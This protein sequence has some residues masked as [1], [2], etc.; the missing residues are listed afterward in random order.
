MS[1]LPQLL[2]SLKQSNASSR[3]SRS[4]GGSGG[5]GRSG[6]STPC[7]L[8]ARRVRV[9]SLGALPITNSVG[10]GKCL[11]PKRRGMPVTQIVCEAS[12][13]AIDND[14]SLVSFH[15]LGNDRFRRWSLLERRSLP[16]WS[17]TRRVMTNKNEIFPPGP[18]I[19]SGKVERKFQRKAQY[20]CFC[21]RRGRT[22]SLLGPQVVLELLKVHIF[23]LRGPMDCLDDVV[24]IV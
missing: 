22:E 9:T 14:L 2:R 4:S 15:V 21:I 11:S 19:T 3:S 8:V 5:S 23:A 16:F 20:C 13:N 12:S 18:S 1:L 10:A 17:I 6:M 24:W 7:F